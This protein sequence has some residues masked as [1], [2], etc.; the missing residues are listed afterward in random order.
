MDHE[1][2]C[3]RVGVASGR[4]GDMIDLRLPSA[5]PA[6]TLA[7]PVHHTPPSHTSAWAL[8]VVGGD[9]AD[10]KDNRLLKHVNVVHV[11]ER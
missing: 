6:R 1:S 11:W 4:D 10:T 5:P 3:A 8:S 2:A 9:I 7:S